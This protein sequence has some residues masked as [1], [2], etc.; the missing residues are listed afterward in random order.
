MRQRQEYDF[1]IIGAGSAGCTLAN[2]LTEDNDV[3]VLLLEAGGLDWDPWIRIPL[4]WGR[5]IQKRLHDWMYF[6]EPEPN[7]DGRKVEC[8]RGKVLGGSS[9]INAMAYVRGNRG[10]YDRWAAAGLTDW[11]YDNALPYFRKQES[12]EGGASKFRGGSGPISTRYSTYRDTLVEAY[13]AAGEAAGF[14]R[15]ADFN[16]EQQEG[17]GRSQTAI[18]KGHRASGSTAYLAPARRRPNLTI[19]T[20]ALAHRIE[21]DDSRASGV[22]YERGGDTFVARA[23]R[24][25]LLCGGVINSPQLLMLSGI[26]PAEKLRR[27]KIDV[28]KSLPGV[29]E[30]LQD[31]AAVLVTFAR[32]KPGPFQRMMRYDRVAREVVRAY[33]FGTGF[34]TDLPGGGVGFVRTSPDS[35]VPDLQLILAGAPIAARPYLPFTQPFAD[36]FGYRIVMLHPESRGRVEL[37]SADPNDSPK[38]F[39]NFLATENDRTTMR[40]AIELVREIASQTPLRPYIARELTPGP[41]RSTAEGIDAYIRKTMITLHHPLGT[42]KMGIDADEMAVVDQTLRVRNIDGLRVVD[43]SVMPDMISGNINAA[44]VMI[45]ERAADLIRKDHSLHHQN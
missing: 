13:L 11:S 7:L 10:D 14:P 28:V 34:A 33:L 15:T 5:I 30:N 26:G 16:G 36:S 19:L 12:W 20:H 27:L 22:K 4:G 42:C 18:H 38:I 23:R 8:A 31:H 45:A 32:S 43:A 9:S 1:V 41:S 44:V 29:G 35:K 3:A 40:K 24:E 37:E 21:F 2:R 39:Q 6:T 25:V 17:F